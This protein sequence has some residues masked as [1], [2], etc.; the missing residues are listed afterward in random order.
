MRQ[1]PA[2]KTNST[3]RR[4]SYRRQA[5]VSA[6]V[7][8]AWHIAL[9][10]PILVCGVHV[11][12]GYETL[13][14][15]FKEQTQRH[16]TL[17]VHTCIIEPHN[18]HTGAGSETW[19]INEMDRAGPGSASQTVTFVFSREN[20]PV[21]RRSIKLFRRTKDTEVS[22][23]SGQVQPCCCLRFSKKA[24]APSFVDTSTRAVASTFKNS[25]TTAPQK[26][27]KTHSFVQ[28]HHRHLHGS[29]SAMS[30]TQSAP[31]PLSSSDRNEASP[32]G[33][34]KK[35]QLEK[36]TGLLPRWGSTLQA[37]SGLWWFAGTRRSCLSSCLT[38]EDGFVWRVS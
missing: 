27:R 10:C 37:K 38:W 15:V 33:R 21:S 19:K 9:L 4:Y 7:D 31:S 17:V 5:D 22:W 18:R 34:F 26:K 2:K 32:S 23:G 1:P 13:H 24:T 8:G 29:A 12:D 6:V 14:V 25:K 11:L 36:R 28:V 20:Q 16:G 30:P 3:D 35:R